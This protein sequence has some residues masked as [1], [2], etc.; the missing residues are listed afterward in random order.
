MP[1]VRGGLLLPAARKAAGSGR[2]WGSGW[3]AS[4]WP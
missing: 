4:R 1:A 3:W 2:A